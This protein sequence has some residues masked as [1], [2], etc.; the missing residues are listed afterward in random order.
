MNARASKGFMIWT[1]ALV[2]TVALLALAVTGCGSASTGNA[3]TVTATGTTA[4]AAGLSL[5]E[6]DNGKSFTVKLGQTV[7]VVLAGNPTTGYAWASDLDDQAATMLTLGSGQ[8]VYTPDT[9]STNLVGSGGKYTFTFTAAVAGTVQLKL[10]Y[11]RSFEAKN[12][13]VQ[14]FSADI[15]IQ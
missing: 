6:A 2:L 3:T 4:T 15:T 13:P 8:P 12:P 7:T 5:T 10:K 9:V 14:T 11:W 1:G